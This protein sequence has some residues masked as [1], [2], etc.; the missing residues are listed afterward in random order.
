MLVGIDAG[1]TGI[2]AALSDG[3]VGDPVPGVPRM[4]HDLGPDDVATALLAGVADFGLAA[5][6]GEIEGVGIGLS[7]FELI[8][9]AEMERI[10][11][12]IRQ[13]LDTRA[14]VAIA[15]DGITSLLGA[16][17]GLRPG[18]SSP[19]EP[20][21]SCSVTTAV[22]PGRTSTAG[23]RC[24]ATTAAG[25]R[26]GRPGCAPRCGP[27][28]GVTARAPYGPRPRRA[29]ARWRGCPRRSCATRRRRRGIVASFAPAVAEAA[30]AGDVTARSIWTQAGE[31]LGAQ[32]GGR[33]APPVLARHPGRRR[34]AGQPVEGRAAAARAVRA[35]ADP[36]LA[37][38]AH[39]GG[40]GHVAGRR[41]RARRRVGHRDGAGSGLARVASGP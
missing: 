22:T 31:D 24:W 16:L 34:A 18:W 9:H 14:P 10:A 11:V 41:G 35:G 25:S 30:R 2:R 15:T 4:E 33:A 29:G 39:R 12:R 32:R 21:S 28:T 6:G 19:R 26:S 8:S 1:Q 3:T 23:A 17:G 20:G 37:R 5:R 40:R 13:R 27:T 36:P 7:G 38:R